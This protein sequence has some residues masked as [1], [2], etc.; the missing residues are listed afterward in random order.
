MY[1]MKDE[2]ILF[3]VGIIKGEGE[4]YFHDERGVRFKKFKKPWSMNNYDLFFVCSI[5]FPHRAL[6]FVLRPTKSINNFYL[7]FVCLIAFPRGRRRHHLKGIH[8]RSDTSR[9]GAEGLSFYCP[10]LLHCLNRFS[11][12]SIIVC[13]EINQRA[14]AFYLFISQQLL[15]LELSFKFVLKEN[16]ILF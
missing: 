11:L 8:S 10:R 7:F 13:F 14:R 5:A 4:F 12:S 15:A 6:L 16:F 9:T 1:E 3:F 2:L